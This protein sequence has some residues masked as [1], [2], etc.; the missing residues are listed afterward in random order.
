MGRQAGSTEGFGWL[1]GAQAFT[2][3]ALFLL[4]LIGWLSS[5]GPLDHVSLS[6]IATISQDHHTST[7]LAA[8]GTAGPIPT[9]QVQSK[10][11]VCD[12]GEPISPRV[13]QLIKSLEFVELHEFLPAPLLRALA[14]TPTTS[15]G[16]CSSLHQDK[17][18]SK[19]VG[20]IFTWLMCYHRFVAL[21]SS[22]HPGKLGQFMAYA[23]TILHAHLEFEGDG[24]RAYDW[25]FRLQVSG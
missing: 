22:F 24:W 18:P 17:H 15:C 13:V 1:Y 6:A 20:D 23:N 5:V 11:S 12:T 19:T 10:W 16:C 4:P 2:R 21:A 9:A 8:L 3:P 7:L 25:A 14:T